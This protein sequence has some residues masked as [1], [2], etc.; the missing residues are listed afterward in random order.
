MDRHDT[1]L[2]KT[3]HIQPQVLK[4]TTAN[5]VHVPITYNLRIVFKDVYKKAWV[6][7]GAWRWK[8]IENGGGARLGET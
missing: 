2:D 5:A 8:Q 1:L 3:Y 7:V 6:G 4:N